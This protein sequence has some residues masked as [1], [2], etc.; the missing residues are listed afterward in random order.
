M[1]HTV[2]KSGE[3]MKPG[4]DLLCRGVKRTVKKYAAS[5]SLRLSRQPHILHIL[6]EGETVYQKFES[7][8]HGEFADLKIP[9]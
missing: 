9:A 3:V 6:W 8:A 7:D 1:P 4:S 2:E 5:W